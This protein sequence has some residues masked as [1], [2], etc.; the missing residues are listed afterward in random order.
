MNNIVEGFK[1][2][3]EKFSEDVAI[4]DKYRYLTYQELDK[5]SSRIAGE[6]IRSGLKKGEFVS[7]YLKRGI[8]TVVSMLGI[9]KAGGVYVALDPE[10]PEERNKYIIDD[11]KSP[12]LI[13][14]SEWLEKTKQLNVTS[15][16][17]LLDKLEDNYKELSIHIEG[18]DLAYV[19]YT[20]GTT[21]NP[22]GT[23]LRHG[24]VINLANWIEE[25]YNITPKDRL[26]QFATFSFDA[27]VYETFVSLLNGSMLYL[28][29]DEDRMSAE[30]FI[31]TIDREGITVITALPTVFFNQF[32]NYAKQNGVDTFGNIRVIGVA[33]ELL[34]GE[35]VRNFKNQ[36]GKEIVLLNLYGPTETTVAA[37]FYKTPD[38]INDNVFS[39]PIGKAIDGTVLY[40][41]NENK[42]Q[43]KIGELG[44]L[45]IASA[46]ISVGYLNQQEKTNE[47]FIKNPF[48]N[49]LGG[50]VYKSGD[51]VKQLEDGN[52]EFVERK[53]TQVKIRGH[54]IEIAE[55][56]NRM[57][58]LKGIDD[59]VVVVEEEDGEKLLKAFY[60]SNKEL[61]HVY[62]INELKKN[63]TSYMIPAKMKRINELPFAPTGKVDRKKLTKLVADKVVMVTDIVKPR[64]DIEEEILNAWKN[65]LNINDIGVKNDFFE[66]GGHSLKIIS[67][68][69][70]LK[71]KYRGLTIKDF[72]DLRTVEKLALKVLED[73][74]IEKV[75]DEKI[76][77]TNLVEYPFLNVTE[78]IPHLRNVLVTGATGFLGI[79]IVKK[80]VDNGVNVTVLV[81]GDK[82]EVRMNEKYNYYFGTDIS[83]RINVLSGELTTKNLG[84]KKEKFNELAFSIDAVIHSAADVRHFGERSHFEKINVEGT[85]NVLDLVDVNPK[86]VFHHISTVGII[87]EIFSEGKWEEFKENNGTNNNLTL[88]NVYNDTKLM[89]EN[90]VLSKLNEGKQ[91]FVYRMGNLIGRYNDGKF[92]DNINNNAFYRM[93]KL[94]T[95][96]GKA[97]KVNWMV[98]FT[99]VDFASE[100]VFKSVTEKSHKQRVYH[101]SHP[102][103]V[104]YDK[105]ISLINDIGLNVEILDKD[106]YED[107]VLTEKL[108]EEASNLVVSQLDGDG[109]IDSSAI[110]DSTKTMESLEILNIPV[111]NT[112]YLSKIINYADKLGFMEID[113]REVRA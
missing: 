75:S 58:Q 24:G 68:L 8:D 99:P 51:L 95:M 60:T 2:A 34:T 108:P 80:L 3:V 73:I 4:K 12:F 25:E 92:Q 21:G 10:H 30:H 88:E 22:K 15:T 105:F 74:K 70:I 41:V 76:E 65:I 47:V 32:S 57:S 37:S 82:A 16:T 84:M 77:F 61:E 20:S 39:V 29:D 42:E 35:V 71:K 90:L 52:I 102:N 64:N 19:I 40:V 104:S 50:M 48:E 106:K 17:I 36:F 91:V 110:Y 78:D 38:E 9:L 63:L 28:I 46:G 113:N 94:M 7:I 98:D 23:L 33:G 6:L 89:A 87:E 11:T 112:E 107:F 86:V 43:C 62:I 45:W 56:E 14:K 31:K 103:P 72:F 49:I 81:R 55:I 93:M 100:V 66:V 69:S 13:T 59:A 67:V 26:L 79:H 18:E 97:P 111:I 44:E 85:R 96:I 27:S 5:E 83:S 53:D 109:A 1:V 101:I 54:R